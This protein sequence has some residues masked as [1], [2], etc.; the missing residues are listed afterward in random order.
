MESKTPRRSKRDR[1]EKSF[2][3]DFLTYMLEAEPL[4]YKEAVNSA[5]GHLWKDAIRSEIDSI[6][7]NYTWELVDLPPRSKTL[8]SK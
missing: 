5:E 4:T 3:S 2:G 8:G 7:H 6:M 1:V